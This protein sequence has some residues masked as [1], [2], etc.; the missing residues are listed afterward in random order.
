MNNDCDVA[1][2]GLS[3]VLPSQIVEKECP[4]PVSESRQASSEGDS[5]LQRRSVCSPF[6]DT[7]GPRVTGDCT[8]GNQSKRQAF[9]LEMKNQKRPV[10]ALELKD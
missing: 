10:L 2:R 7:G 4:N 5:R 8:G 3:D 1:S 9:T 6:E